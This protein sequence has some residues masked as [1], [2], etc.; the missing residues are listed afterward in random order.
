MSRIAIFADIHGNLPALEA[1]LADLSTRRP[2]IVVNLGDHLSGPLWP[3]ETAHLLMQQDWYHISGNHDRIMAGPDPTILNPS[4]AYAFSQL[5]EAELR[6]LGG[7]PSFLEIAD[8]VGLCHGAPGRDDIYLLETV[9]HGRARLATPAEIATRL[10]D[11][12]PPIILCGH[13]HVPRIVQLNS[14]RLFI[15]P[16]SLGLQAYDDDGPTPHVIEIGS[17]HAR[18]AVMDRGDGGWRVE[19]VALEYDHASAA[20]RAERNHRPDWQGALLTGFFLRSDRDGLIKCDSF[21]ASGN[22]ADGPSG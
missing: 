3:R 11:E 2:D 10:G 18:Y 15:N 6:W 13:S 22:R 19:I 4:D 1:A 20:R 16:G 17:P 7:L 5:G 12:T 8:G 21:I 14:G 9:E